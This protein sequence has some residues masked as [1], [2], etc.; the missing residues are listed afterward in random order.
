MVVIVDFCFLR[1]HVGKAL[2]WVA[3]ALIITGC[4]SAPAS[5]TFSNSQS[6]SRSYDEVWEDLVRFFASRNIQIKNIAKDSGVIYAEST[7]YEQDFADCG[8]PG[9]S[10]VVSKVVSFNVFVSRSEATPTVHVNT[11]FLE[12][13]Q[14]DRNVWTVECNSK[15]VIEKAILNSVRQ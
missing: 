15:G 7:R 8:S 12:T 5:Y 14:F 13:R 9:V 11:K 2:I 6:F 3:L 4:A 10:R 1:F